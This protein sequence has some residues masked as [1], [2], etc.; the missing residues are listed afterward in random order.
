MSHRNARL[1]VHGRRL[2][3][4]RVR[5][6]GWPVAHA[7]KAQGV[8]RQC[9]RRWIARYDL[10][11]EAGLHDRSSRPHH[12]PRRTAPA[13]E[14]RVVALRR[15]QRRGQDWLGPELG[16]APRPRGRRRPRRFG[17]PAR[18]HPPALPLAKRQG[19]TV[20]PNPANRM[21]LPAGLHIQRR[22]FRSPCP[23]LEN[24]NTGRRHTALGGQPPISR[25]SPT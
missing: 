14:E 8:S 2:L 23:W 25:P 9:A 7:A 3:V 5:V 6:L 20:Q 16:L 19:R 10:R 17:G 12:S 22:T 24:Y 4:H 18:V 15:E 13:V 21:G 11:G 1:N